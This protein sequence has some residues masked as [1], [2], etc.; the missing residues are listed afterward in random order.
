MACPEAS[1]PTVISYCQN[2][3]SMKVRDIFSLVHGCTQSQNSVWCMMD[4]VVGIVQD[5][6]IYESIACCYMN[7]GM[8]LRHGKDSIILS[9]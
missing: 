6:V 4:I 5:W 9:C 3:G 2:V 7:N 8:F 1:I